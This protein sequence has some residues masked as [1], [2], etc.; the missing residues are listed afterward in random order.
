MMLTGKSPCGRTGESA[1]VREPHC[2]FVIL[3]LVVVGNATITPW[4]SAA[5]TLTSAAQVLSL[6]AELANQQLPVKVKGVVTAAES[7]WDGRFFIEDESSGV[8]V[9]N[10]AVEHPEPGDVVEVTGITHSGAYAP[11]ITTPIWKKVGT[12]PLPEAR[13]VSVERV[14]SGVL[15]G[16]RVEVAGVVRAVVPGSIT[17]DMDLASGGYR[18]HVVVRPPIA[19]ADMDLIG[20]KVRVT[21]TAVASWNATLRQLVSVVIFAP[22]QSDLTVEEREALD[23]FDKPVLSL[24]SIEQ[25]HRDMVPGER[26][27]VRGVVTLHRPGE[28]LFLQ[29]E[30]GGLHI[31][32]RQSDNCAIGQVVEAVGFPELEHFLPVLQDA[33]IRQTKESSARVKPQRVTIEEIRAGLHHAELITLPAKVIDRNLRTRVGPDGTRL[34]RTVLLLQQDDLLFTAEA[35]A[36]AE[37]MN[38][39]GI[40]IGSEIEVTGVCFA[41]NGSD[42]KLK[43]L[44]LLLP[45]AKSFRL[46]TQPS[47]W[48]PQRLMIGVGIL[49][50]G[51]VIGATWTVRVSRQNAVLGE[52]VREREKTQKE[53]QEAHD[54]LEHRVEERTAQLESQITARR[55]SELQFKAVLSERTRLAQELHD[56]LEQTL[57]G[58]A[59]QLDTT[60]KLFQARPETANHHLGL[61]RDLVAQGQVEVRR[62]VWDLRS[63]A[64]EQFDLPSA[65]ATSGEYFTAGAT[66]HFE[67]TAK[68]RVRPLRE[69]VEENLLR[70][71]Q[72]AMTNVVKHSQA[73]IAK[74]ELDY[75]PKNVTLRVKDNGKGFQQSQCAG[76]TDGHFGLLGIS[77]RAKKLGAELSIQS[78]PGGGTVLVVN[79]AVDREFGP[80]KE[81][82]DEGGK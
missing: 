27:H 67:V 20:A 50:I 36:P 69:T 78:E 74:V 51:S 9:N 70:I 10:S 82:P 76:P 30:R 68:G 60:S 15:D 55:E 49:L 4:Q 52:L 35:E 39:S 42:K 61:A 72:E 23:P 17:T 59:L 43:S 1:K 8:F 18:L 64:L 28:D 25:Y 34:T 31:R 7:V 79:V 81:L 65:L 11:V 2:I 53:L 73:T 12:A 47:R 38:L 80:D 13:K 62:S 26:V 3:A 45:N 58:V 77:E 46:L 29:D 54:F 57:T 56:T 44:Q 14:M 5:Q 16:Q 71:A 75:G 24:N 63:R 33:T 37:E 66:T 32:S 48:T 19:M 22:L 40:A 6:S 21:G 41:E